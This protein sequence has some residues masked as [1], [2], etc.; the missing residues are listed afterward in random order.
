MKF[1]HVI[2]Q[3]EGTV[4]YRDETGRLHLGRAMGRSADGK[5]AV[6]RVADTTYVRRA[7]GRGELAIVDPLDDF[8][9]VRQLPALEETA[10][11]S[12]VAVTTDAPLVIQR[13]IAADNHVNRTES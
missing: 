2:A 9:P 11:P 7:L 4:P 13:G 8:G 3:G 5:P 6:E 10:P 1:L 12:E